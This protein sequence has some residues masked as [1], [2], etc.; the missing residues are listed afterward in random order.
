[1]TSSLNTDTDKTIQWIEDGIKNRYINYYEYSEFQNQKSMSERM[2]CIVYK[3]NWESFNTVVTLKSFKDTYHTKEIANEIQILNEVHL[4]ANI[5]KFFG[6]TKRKN[7][8]YLLILE[9]AEGGT[10]RD[11]LEKNPNKLNFNVKL[12]FAIQI[13]DAVSYLHQKNI[14]HCDL[15]SKNILIHQNKAKLS[16]FGL[17]RRLAEV[18]NSVKLASIEMLPYTDPLLFEELN[19][20]QHYKANKKSD[21]YSIGVLL[22]EISS[23]RLPFEYH[24][25]RTL[26][27]E[28]QN[29]KRESP[30][31][32]TPDKYV[33]IYK[34][35]WQ[36]N[37]NDRPN[38]HQ[39][40]SGL[41]SLETLVINKNE[42]IKNGDNEGDTKLLKSNEID[43]LKNKFHTMKIDG[44]PLDLD[45][46]KTLSYRK[47]QEGG[48]IKD[49]YN[50]LINQYIISNNKNDNKQQNNILL[51]EF[52]RQGIVTEKD[53]FKALEY[54]LGEYYFYGT[55][56]EK[57]VVKA[58]ELYKAATE[59]GDINAMCD[60][61][62]CYQHGIGTVKDELKAFELYKAAA[63]KGHIT[64][65]NYL[66]E[67]YQRGIGTVKDEIKAFELYK[68]LVNKGHIY[69][70]YDLGNCYRDGIGTEKNEFK[71]L[72]LYKMAEKRIDDNGKSYQHGIKAA[73]NETNTFELYKV[74]TEKSN[75]QNTQV[76][77]SSSNVTFDYNE[78]SDQSSSRTLKKITKLFESSSEQIIRKFKLN[79]GL[80]ST[81]SSMR[82]SIQA[83]TV[84]DGEL[85]MSLY[86]GQPLIYT[87]INSS[88]YYNENKPFDACINFPIA[89]IIYNGDLLKSFLKHKD[90]DENFSELYGDFLARKF[91]VGGRLFIKDFN[92]ATSAQVDILKFYLLYIYKSAKC[93]TKI[94]F[95]NLFELS[96]LPKIVTLDG[97][98]LST[99]AKLITWMNDL[100]QKKI[101]SVI[102][103]NNLVPVTEL[104]HNISLDDHV[105]FIEKQPGVANFKERLTFEEWIG[106][107]VHDN[108]VSWTENFHIFR[109][110]IIDKD[111]EIKISEKTIIN[112]IEIPEV[113]LN[114]KIY[115]KI[116]EPST[117]LETSLISNNIFS[118][119][120]L[121]TF[122]FTNNNH[123][124]SYKD[125]VYILLKHER[126]EILLN[127]DHIKPTKEFER[128]IE[129][130]LNSV[131]P[132]KA[133]RDIFNKYGHLFPQRIILGR[134]LRNILP[135]ESVSFD[136]FDKIDFNLV[137]SV[138]TTSFYDC[139]FNSELKISD[140][141]QNIPN[142]TYLLT[143]EGE[144]IKKNDIYNWIQNTDKNL[145]IIEFDNVIPLYKIFEIKQQRKIDEVIKNGFRIIMT[146]ITDLKDLNNNNV[147]HYK[148]INLN[149][150]SVFE[151]EDYEVF[152][153]IITENNTKLEEICVNFGLYDF[154]GFY[155][156]IKKLKETNV[157]ITKCYVLWMIV[158]NPSKLLVLSP[159]NREFQVDCVKVSVTLQIDESNHYIKT[160]PIPISQGFTTVVHAY[161]PSTNYEPINIIK[162]VG[163]NDDH[164][165]FQIKYDRSNLITFNDN[166][167]IDLHIC[168]L[169]EANK[170]LKID[171][172]ERECSLDLIG[173]VLTK[174][175][176]NYKL[177]NEIKSAEAKS[178]ES[179]TP[180]S[181]DTE[182]KDIPF[183]DDQVIGYKE[184]LNYKLPSEIR[185][186]EAKSNKS[187]TLSSI[188]TK[189][190]DI[191]FIDDQV[192]IEKSN[193][194]NINK[195]VSQAY[196]KKSNKKEAKSNKSDTLASIDTEL[197][198]IPFQVIIE[199]SNRTNINK[200]V[201]QV[202]RKKSNKKA[203]VRWETSEIIE[204]L[205]FI[206]DNYELWM[207]SRINACYKVIEVTNSNRDSTSV[208]AKI[209]TIIKD[210]ERYLK[211]GE[212]SSLLMN[213]DEIFNLVNS[214]Y[215]KIE[216][217]MIVNKKME[218]NKEMKK[219][220]K[221]IKKKSEEMTEITNNFRNEVKKMSEEKIDKIIRET[222]TNE[223]NEQ[224]RKICE[225]KVAEIMKIEEKLFE[226]LDSTNH[227]YESLKNFV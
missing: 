119:K 215:N 40:L 175:N 73:K 2:F 224:M 196:R 137:S 225:D 96:L 75:E 111:Y 227:K 125:N 141:F 182:L 47:L 61:G 59:K 94:Q 136:N 180:S 185:L 189:L 42:I 148:R 101:A 144:V 161:C 90:N 44:N 206:D 200:H 100:Y 5:I 173:Y 194:T 85:K 36:S 46:Y 89:E 97:E 71:A 35:C 98:E 186:A 49:N 10:L 139:N 127:K 24:N 164:I 69:S 83:I 217:K 33:D 37:P 174:E 218:E 109:G 64:S 167:E 153:S 154:S 105:T 67:C 142:L 198:D 21:V 62:Y 197:K 183:I 131:K 210:F 223:P 107:E 27:T 116:I 76:T 156:I 179:D 172:E 4:H 203:P 207:R 138:P 158:G 157:D 147:M 82:P 188:D 74:T 39:I 19:N 57:N 126:Y 213:N 146:G 104:R 11:H 28:L 140:Y 7:N 201:S 17:S 91:L 204:L 25:S 23:E 149:P 176:L 93:S 135:K 134:S 171:Y 63:E 113:N 214:I 192:I 219:S 26:I 163:W 178:N 115:L 52:L 14:I 16:D 162:L 199:K 70:I 114:E 18:Q 79:H 108:L 220:E 45:N 117:N 166:I 124:K 193:R 110:L 165:N 81:D 41:K 129:N 123:L 6:I 102:S 65:M 72:E 209:R 168:L 55:G 128:Q 216:N 191:P 187:D 15:N 130:A 13:S 159:N 54:Q 78:T 181:I 150:E 8:D 212:S 43:S 30:V 190:K 121:S 86:E 9:Y 1:M 132:L 29:G 58:F 60:L 145:E 103:Y 48:I 99:H 155:A 118:F 170:N 184:N 50:Q 202:Y 31:P 84:K 51:G 211:T 12:Q 133:L 169:S 92:L 32:G 221:E 34:S 106:D 143:Q 87:Y 226:I 66:G 112:F 160:D 205:N 95:N 20:V 151:D 122:P 88:N 152:G 68:E 77:Y 208:Y 22:W 56:T 38:I 195:H 177:P 80:I 53:E 222:Y 120:N 3:A